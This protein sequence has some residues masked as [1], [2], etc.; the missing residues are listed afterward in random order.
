MLQ[1]IWAP[2]PT[3]IATSIPPTAV[4]DLDVE[5]S[6]TKQHY[7]ARDCISMGRERWIG[8]AVWEVVEADVSQEL[9]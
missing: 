1:S 2:V 6:V 5:I 7:D 8:V 4:E 9:C 3:G